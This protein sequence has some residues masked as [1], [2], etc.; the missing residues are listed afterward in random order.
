MEVQAYLKGQMQS[1]KL[2]ES[3]ERQDMQAYMHQAIK[4]SQKD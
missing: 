3:Q 2:T 4:S 1:K